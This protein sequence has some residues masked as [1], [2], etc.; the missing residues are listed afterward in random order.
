[1]LQI[2]CFTLYLENE[3]A[4]EGDDF[5]WGR[6]SVWWIS[7]EATKKNDDNHQHNSKKQTKHAT[8]TQMQNMYVQFDVESN[9]NDRRA[10]DTTNPISQL[11]FRSCV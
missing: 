8:Q 1:M 11:T 7:K 5:V 9:N 4:P 10:A 3:G 6:N 2:L